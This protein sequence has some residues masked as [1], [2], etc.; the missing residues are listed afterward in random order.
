MKSKYFWLVALT[1]TT[2]LEEALRNNLIPAQYVHFI[3]P[4]A[5]LLGFIVQKTRPDA[6]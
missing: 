2:A 6:A 1:I 3:A 4:A 5:T